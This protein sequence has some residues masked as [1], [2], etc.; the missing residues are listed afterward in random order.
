VVTENISA[1]SLAEEVSF[2]ATGSCDCDSKK[3]KPL[4][5]LA[6]AKLEQSQKSVQDECVKP[7]R[8]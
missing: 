6:S 4:R 2:I 7:Q 5:E 8:I 1:A 3:T